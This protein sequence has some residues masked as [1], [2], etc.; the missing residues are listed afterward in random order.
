MRG[1]DILT[2]KDLIEKA[3]TIKRSEYFPLR[4]EL[5]AQT[6]IAKKQTQALDKTDDIDETINKKPTLKNFGK[7]D[8]IHGDNYSF[9]KHYRK[10]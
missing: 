8:L 7:S 6:D 5:K 10:Y 9:Y 1:K 2:E 3:S 4:K